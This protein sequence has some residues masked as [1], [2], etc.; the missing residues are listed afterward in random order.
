MSTNNIGRP[1]K[2]P[3]ER[4]TIRVPALANEAQLARWRLAAT[5]AGKSLSQW[6]R[7]ALDKVAG[8]E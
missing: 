4:Y 3:S 6:V 8:G 1:K 2:P 5:K 7:D